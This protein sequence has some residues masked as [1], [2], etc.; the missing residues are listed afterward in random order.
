MGEKKPKKNKQ[1]Q[2]YEFHSDKHLFSEDV[3]LPKRN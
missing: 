1:K 3:S 2:I